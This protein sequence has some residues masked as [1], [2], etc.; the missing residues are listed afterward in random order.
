M[1]IF[2][3]M[4]IY[5]SIQ[6][7]SLK[8]HMDN[9]AYQGNRLSRA[10]R[11]SLDNIKSVFA[12][13]GSLILAAIATAIGMTFWMAAYSYSATY[14]YNIH[15]LL[16]GVILLV[17]LIPIL[18]YIIAVHGFLWECIYTVLV[19]ETVVK[20]GFEDITYT[21][22]N[23][24]CLFLIT[25]EYAVVFVVFLIPMF[26]FVLPILLSIMPS[27]IGFLVFILLL[28]ILESVI[29]FWTMLQWA[30]FVE[31][32]DLIKGLNPLN[33]IKLI[34]AM[35][36]NAI[37][38]CLSFLGIMVPYAIITLVFQILCVPAILLPF[39]RI[40]QY[41]SLAYIA[42]DFYMGSYMNGDD[43]QPLQSENQHGM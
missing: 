34:V 23:G 5:I 28:M 42:A 36:V 35:P 38:A 30:V 6:I 15:W 16:F 13:G 32:F 24:A 2:I 7:L 22:K 8:D 31:S 25:L 29:L 37:T 14:S 17:S 41:T 39:I 1:I 43:Y 20:S 33:S 27:I 40:A 11:F 12:W 4:E 26:I 18:I 21:L 3:I 19:G 9:S 10:L